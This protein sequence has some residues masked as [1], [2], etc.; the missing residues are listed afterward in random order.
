[1]AGELSRRGFIASITLRNTK[2]IDVLAANS[3]ATKSVGIQVKTNQGSTQ[4]W[5]LDQKVEQGMATNLFFVFVNLNNGKSAPSFHIVP[6][7]TVA[8][9]SRG[10]NEKWLAGKKRDGGERKNTSMRKFKDLEDE[11]LDRWD[12]LNL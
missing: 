3:D 10:N 6:S 1:M 2:G 12:L 4:Q 9:Y 7:Q 11:Y 5:I 8:Q